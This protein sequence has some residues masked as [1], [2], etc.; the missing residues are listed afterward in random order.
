MANEKSF[1]RVNCFK[2]SHRAPLNTPKIEESSPTWSSMTSCSRWLMLA[3]GKRHKRRLLFWIL[4]SLL[5]RVSRWHSARPPI[6]MVSLG[7]CYGAW[8]PPRWESSKLPTVEPQCCFFF[9]TRRHLTSVNL[10]EIQQNVFVGQTGT[11]RCNPVCTGRVMGRHKTDSFQTIFAWFSVWW[12]ISPAQVRAV[13]G[14]RRRKTHA[15][16]VESKR[17]RERRRWGVSWGGD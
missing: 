6:S 16:R 12:S 5:V 1:I 2:L 15:E 3:C 9:L 14:N 11:N 8:V 7:P 13:G 4:Y 17:E 10:A